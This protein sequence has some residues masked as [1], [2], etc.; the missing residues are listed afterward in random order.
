MFRNFN[1]HPIT[2]QEKREVCDEPVDLP[3][4]RL[5]SGRVASNEMTVC[6]L[7]TDSL[8]HT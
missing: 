5:T 1:L 6:S 7:I 3:D 4:I 8:P 2:S